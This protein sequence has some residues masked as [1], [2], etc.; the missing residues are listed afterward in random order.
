MNNDN[1]P[2]NNIENKSNNKTKIF[3]TIL[4]FLGVLLS[5]VGAIMQF[6]R[7]PT[8]KP[9]DNST[10]DEN[11]DSM[12]N[13][14]YSYTFE[15]EFKTINGDIVVT[16]ITKVDDNNYTINYNGEEFAM[17]F[18]QEDNL[19]LSLTGDV[20]GQCNAKNLLL[21]KRDK[22]IENSEGLSINF[23]RTN[24]GYYFI[25]GRCEPLDYPGD[26]YDQNWNFLGMYMGNSVLSDG[27]IF[28]SKSNDANRE[29]GYM[30]YDINGSLLNESNDYYY[31]TS[32]VYN[33]TC[34]ALALSDNKV[35]VVNLVTGDNIEIT[36]INSNR[37]YGNNFYDKMELVD[38]RIHITI[39]EGEFYLDLESLE[40]TNE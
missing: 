31:S 1:N 4:L 8:N 35:L 33:D 26:V 6:T 2:N 38:Q 34:Y 37:D 27:N 23:I 29:P 16:S 11:Q 10:I 15:D 18:V 13:T 39:E 30:L 22:I 36:D 25:S 21:N 12:D 17:S 9:L 5:S 28:V 40:V 7:K 32:L 3:G 24:D 19:Y 20:S 14:D